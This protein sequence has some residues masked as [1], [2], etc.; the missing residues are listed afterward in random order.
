MRCHYLSAWIWVWVFVFARLAIKNG[1]CYKRYCVGG[2]CRKLFGQCCARSSLDSEAPTS[3]GVYTGLAWLFGTNST[4][5]A[6]VTAWKAAVEKCLVSAAHEAVF[7]T[8]QANNMPRSFSTESKFTPKTRGFKEGLALHAVIAS[9]TLLHS[10][11]E[12]STARLRRKA[13]AILFSSSSRTQW[14]ACLGLRCPLPSELCRWGGRALS[15]QPK[16]QCPA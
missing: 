1:L 2:G 11:G 4:A 13:S 9:S 8:P 14:S 12:D 3:F 15:L 5:G 7:R 10:A 6:G 16:R